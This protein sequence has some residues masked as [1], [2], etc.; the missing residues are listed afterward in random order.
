MPWSPK[1]YSGPTVGEDLQRSAV[2]TGDI[3]SLSGI[4]IRREW[5]CRCL[6]LYYLI[7]VGRGV[8]VRCLV[9]R[10]VCN[11]I[12]HGSLITFISPYYGSALFIFC[13]AYLRKMVVFSAGATYLTPCRAL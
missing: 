7:F 3:L 2:V 1:A 12:V 6:Y 4:R 10:N 9:E 5:D 11:E 8:R 13:P